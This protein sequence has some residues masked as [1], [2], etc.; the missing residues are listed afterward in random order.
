MSSFLDARCQG[1]GE[2]GGDG[3]WLR[4]SRHRASTP[5]L[6]G[7]RPQL[8]DFPGKVGKRARAYSDEGNADEQKPHQLNE[9]NSG[10]D[11]QL[12]HVKDYH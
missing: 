12:M 10:A 8:A 1:K 6:P 2:E 3:F 5:A 9:A 4:A 7:R 11:C